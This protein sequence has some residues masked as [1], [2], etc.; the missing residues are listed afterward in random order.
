MR[1]NFLTINIATHYEK[2]PVSSLECC[3]RKEP[4]YFRTLSTKFS[5]FWL[6][7][8]SLAQL[9]IQDMCILRNTCTPTMTR[10]YLPTPGPIVHVG[11]WKWIF[12]YS[13]SSGLCIFEKPLPEGGWLFWKGRK[14]LAGFGGNTSEAYSCERWWLRFLK[15]VVM[16]PEGFPSI[17]VFLLLVARR[18]KNKE[19]RMW[20]FCENLQGHP[21]SLQKHMTHIFVP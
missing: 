12:L 16:I 14:T 2:F 7:I 19:L 5:F 10:L 6:N 20:I 8:S 13:C 1:G 3:R 15:Q 17:H 11:I 9:M 18:Q 21:I 4:F